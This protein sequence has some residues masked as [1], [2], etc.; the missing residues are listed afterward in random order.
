[1]KN[2]EKFSVTPYPLGN[3]KN[4]TGINNVSFLIAAPE[5]EGG[6]EDYRLEE[7]RPHEEHQGRGRPLQ[8]D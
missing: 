4:V 2:D 5:R 1:M 7:A 6:R 3:H 8:R